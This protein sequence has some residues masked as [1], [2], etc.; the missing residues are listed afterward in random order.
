MVNVDVAGAVRLAVNHLA[1]MGHVRIGL[2][3]GQA[4]RYYDAVSAAFA[5]CREE[6]ALDADCVE[7]RLPV[8][9]EKRTRTIRDWF[10][11]LDARPTALIVENGRVA[12]AVMA[13][14]VR[15]G[16]AVPGSV[17]LLAITGS[18]DAGHMT[19]GMTCV[20]TSALD[21]LKRG[22]QILAERVS[23]G[24]GEAVRESQPARFVPGRTCRAL[25][26]RGGVT[27]AG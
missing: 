11:A 2:V 4:S 21:V 23:R 15:H 26:R 20:L 1:S 24:G 10:Q 25:T 12:S 8:G 13:E 7:L 19:A 16:I 6:Y 18:A 22:V 27:M 14:F 5:S 3:N 9:R 17:S